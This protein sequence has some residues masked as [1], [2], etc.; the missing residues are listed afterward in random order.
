MKHASSKQ[1]NGRPRLKPFQLI[2]VSLA[3]QT[4]PGKPRPKL[5]L[6]GLLAVSVFAATA[7]SGAQVTAAPGVT[8]TTTAP[9]A[10][11]ASAPRTWAADAAQNELVALH[12]PGSYLRYRM[13]VIDEKGDQ[14]RDIIE[15]KDGT[16]ARL[17]LRDGRPLTVDED[18]A[19]RRRLNDM[20][21]SPANFARH[22]K[23]D[24]SGKKIASD[25]IKL[26]PDA[27]IYTYTLDQPQTGRNAEAPEIVLDYKPNPRFVPPT[28]TSQA[29]TGLQGRLWIESKTHQL[30]RMEGTIF[31]PV[32]LGWGILAHIYPGGKLVLEQVNAGEQRWI[33]DQFVQQVS[34]RALMV[35]TLNLRV[36]IG[37]SDFQTLPG[38]I[39]YQDAI[40]ILLAT[41]LPT[42]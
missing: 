14:V 5:P 6:F 41:P 37:A 28:T 18:Q 1:V 26:M 10:L 23:N 16:V 2:R 31:Q 34:V 15:C 22:I 17:I 4:V 7:S 3:L 9:P 40:K 13:H 30:V 21:A 20:I 39:P 19:E 29:L 12:H 25:M 8:K 42:H 11:M 33:F 32:N 38:P 35:K 36:K 27:M 24:A